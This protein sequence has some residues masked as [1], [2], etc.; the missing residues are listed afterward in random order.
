MYHVTA[1]DNE[2]KNCWTSPCRRKATRKPAKKDCL[3]WL[4]RSICN[5]RTG[6]STP[7]DASWPSTVTREKAPSDWCIPIKRK[8]RLPSGAGRAV[9]SI[10]G[11]RFSARATSAAE[12]RRENRPRK[13]RPKPVSPL[14]TAIP[15]LALLRRKSVDRV[16]FLLTA[17]AAGRSRSP[18]WCC[19]RGPR[20]R[21]GGRCALRSWPGSGRR[22][23]GKQK[24][25]F[26]R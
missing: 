26:A 25:G 22:S 23:P 16:S 21:R 7:R 8:D 9:K 5:F 14:A 2:G 10:R 17:E 19:P 3:C 4:R 18:G 6:S 24:R 13:F 1:Y 15:R 12:S 20:R 11:R